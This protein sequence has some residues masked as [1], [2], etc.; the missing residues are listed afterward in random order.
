MTKLIRLG[1]EIE[2][3]MN[4]ELLDFDIGMYHKG[5]EI[6]HLSGWKAERDG[7]INTDGEDSPFEEDDYVELIS[8]IMKG[9]DGFR[10]EIN[11]FIEQFNYVEL[12]RIF[13]FNNSC[14]S[15]VHISINR[16]PRYFYDKVIKSAFIKTREYFISK[17][18][19]S[20]LSFET[21][22]LII[23]QYDRHYASQDW[24]DCKRNDTLS[25]RNSEFNFLSEENGKGLEWR[26]PNMH[27]ISTWDEFRE[28]WDIVYSSVQFLVKNSK[29][30]RKVETFKIDMEK[31]EIKEAYENN[32]EVVVLNIQNNRETIISGGTESSTSNPFLGT[33]GGNVIRYV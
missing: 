18:Q 27:G 6:P 14:G 20:N 8:P 31:G 22:R 16:K 25:F 24:V 4:S 17:I 26:A 11:K 23:N 13:F 33:V 29:S 15:H 3:I 10:L 5:I 7:S 32:E 12:N 19:S 1:I 30:W 2:A 21:K 9:R 28:F